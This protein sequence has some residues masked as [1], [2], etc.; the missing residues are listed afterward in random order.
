MA[1]NPIAEI[2]GN[3]IK[4]EAEKQGVKLWVLAM[5][6]NVSEETLYAWV[7]GRRVIT[8]YGLVRVS[9]ILGV[10]MEQLTHGII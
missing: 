2:I 6:L 1:K 7:E 8:V 3:N 10:T 4:T 5:R 9:R